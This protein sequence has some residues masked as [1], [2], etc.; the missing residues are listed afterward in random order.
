MRKSMRCSSLFAPLLLSWLLYPP[1]SL[2]YEQEIHTASRQIVE[3]VQGRELSALAVVDFTDLDGNATQLGRFL[4]EEFSVALSSATSAIEIIDRTHLKALVQESK[5]SATGLI[6]PKTAR[7]LGRIAGAQ[8]LVTGTI[9]PFGDE[10]RLTIKVLSTETARHLYSLALSIPRTQAID[11]LLRRGLQVASAPSPAPAGGGPDLRTHQIVQAGAL[12]VGLQGCKLSGSVLTCETLFTAQEDLQVSL[13]N[14]SRTFDEAGNE[15]TAGKLLLGRR[16]GAYYSLRTDL[17]AG[18]PVRAAVTFEGVG[19]GTRT[20]T[21]LELHL[22]R[23]GTV[24]FRNVP[25]SR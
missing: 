8:A 9:T 6:D 14:G 1:L 3:G 13:E 24:V 22:G 4:A 19:S 18:V 12:S 16:S 25:I 7:E 23:L 2:A 20:L 21:A 11:D 15:Y 17:I 10:V 5:L